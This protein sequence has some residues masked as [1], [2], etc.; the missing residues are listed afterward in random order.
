M[1]ELISDNAEQRAFTAAAMNTLQ[2]K[3]RAPHAASHTLAANIL[4][5]CRHIYRLDTFGVVPAS[6][7]AQRSV[8]LPLTHLSASNT[9]AFIISHD[10]EQSRRCCGR[11]QRHRVRNYR[12]A[13][14]SGEVAKEEERRTRACL[15]SCASRHA[16]YW[17]RK[18]KEP[19]TWRAVGRDPK[20]MKIQSPAVEWYPVVVLAD[21][22]KVILGLAL[23][24]RCKQ[25]SG[26]TRN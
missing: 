26:K 23:N 21:L 22:G 8:P 4:I 24:A 7:S 19:G 11:I 3:T 1:A 9:D 13:G 12:S 25:I 6:S 2:C 15:R 16:G 10:R 17:G 14:S 18:R 20:C 5:L